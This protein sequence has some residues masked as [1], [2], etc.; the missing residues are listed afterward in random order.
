MFFIYFKF[1]LQPYD[2]NTLKIIFI[3]IIAFLP[4]YFIPHIHVLIIDIMMRSC[5]VGGIFILLLL[6]TE[7]APELN[8]KIRKNLKHFSINL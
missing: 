6:K 7:A 4:G 3:S 8:N 2:F 5:I 1:K